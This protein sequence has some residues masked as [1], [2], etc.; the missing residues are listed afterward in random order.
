M[1]YIRKSSPPEETLN[2]LTH[3]LGLVLAVV[4]LVFLI[5]W[6]SLEGDIWYRIGLF[7]YGLSLVLLY[8]SSTF[9][10]MLPRSPAKSRF[11]FYDHAS[12]FVYIAG[13]YTPLLLIS[14]G[15]TTAFILLG[16]V[17]LLAVFGMVFKAVWLEEYPLLS[18]AMYFI[19]GLLILLVLQP[20]GEAVGWTSF[21]LLLG[22]GSCY[23]V[24]V[25]FFAWQRLMY[26]HVIWHVFVLAG[27]TCHFFAIYL[28]LPLAA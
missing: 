17:W 10:H 8:F 22:G 27:S 15:D 23:A 20:L 26:Y 3:G 11:Q 5:R 1:I 4:A 18:T 19:M 21:L 6:G 24:G 28:A 13:T 25:F 16:A 7:A 12:I 14:L 2:Y 9:Y